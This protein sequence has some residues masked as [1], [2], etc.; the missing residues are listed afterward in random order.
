MSITLNWNKIQLTD[1]K[2]I[3]NDL[4]FQANILPKPEKNKTMWQ[5]S[6]LYLKQMDLTQNKLQITTYCHKQHLNNTITDTRTIT[7]QNQ[8]HYLY[9]L[10]GKTIMGKP[11]DHKTYQK[12]R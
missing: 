2:T 1:I 7:M 4:L 6:S 8:I 3:N 5:T 9:T 12:T 10:D 11:A